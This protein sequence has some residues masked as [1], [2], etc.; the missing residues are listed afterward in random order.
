MEV[1]R[2][3]NE[4]NI[5]PNHTIRAIMYMDEEMNQ[6][7]G[8]TYAQ[9]VKNNNITHIAA[10]ES[11]AG[12]TT[13]IGFSTTDPKILKILQ[14]WLPLLEPYGIQ[15]I[16]EGWGGVDIGPLKDQDIPLIGLNVDPHRYFEYH[17]C[18]NDTFDQVHERELQLGS[19]TITAL[20]YLIDKYGLR[21]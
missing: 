17:H 2:I 18:A 6:R 20:I 12:G 8:K 10:L 21:E 13:P 4:L 9:W 15:Y 19:A 5:K 3:F 16:K 7:G 1:I 11:D 14:K